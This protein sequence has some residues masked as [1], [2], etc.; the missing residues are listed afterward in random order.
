M[1]FVSRTDQA[2]LFKDDININT[3][4]LTNLSAIVTKLLQQ[5]LCNSWFPTLEARAFFKY[6]HRKKQFFNLH[7]TFIFAWPLKVKPK[8][9]KVWL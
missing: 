5:D 1:P 2:S 9:A 3:G 8:E 6:E 7:L 4:I